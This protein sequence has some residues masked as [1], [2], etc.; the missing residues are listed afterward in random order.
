MKTVLTMLLILGVSTISSANLVEQ[1]NFGSEGNFSSIT[2]Y[3][4]DGDGST[5]PTPRHIGGATISAHLTRLGPRAADGSSLNT[6]AP[7]QQLDHRG[8]VLLQRIMRLWVMVEQ[9][10]MRFTEQQV[11][12]VCRGRMV[13]LRITCES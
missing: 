10:Q 2:T 12:K 4:Y 11:S 7:E 9:L 6:T 3:N 8:L 13:V 1:W 5:P